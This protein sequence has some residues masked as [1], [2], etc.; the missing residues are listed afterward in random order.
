MS[1]LEATKAV[2]IFGS[3][4]LVLIFACLIWWSL[5]PKPSESTQ[6]ETETLLLNALPTKAI[7]GSLSA[8]G[9][10]ELD[11][12]GRALL[13]F[14]PH[15]PIVA[16]RFSHLRL[17]G[18]YSPMIGFSFAWRNSVNPNNLHRVEIPTDGSS[19]ALGDDP[20]WR[21]GIV[22]ML[23]VVE[24]IYGGVSDA[25]A[26]RVQLGTF[27]LAHRLSRSQQLSDHL[28]SATAFRGWDLRSINSLRFSPTVLA[29]VVWLVLSLA[30]AA[31]VFRRRNPVLAVLLIGGVV[32]WLVLDGLW[33]QQL[34]FQNQ[35]SRHQFA[36][37][38]VEQRRYFDLDRPLAAFLDPLT[39]FAG[40]EPVRRALVVTP[41]SYYGK[42]AA[43]H[44]LP[45]PA[46]WWRN[47]NALAR[48]G[49][50]VGKGDAIVLFQ[51]ESDV[52]LPAILGSAGIEFEELHRDE[53]GV[54]FLVIGRH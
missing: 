8:P 14:R 44:L 7:F 22:E 15:R 5:Q 46:V 26:R 18:Q 20:G 1:K 32:G 33:T 49:A 16:R 27:E 23:L 10:F 31:V 21:G 9:E 28:A 38:S 24:P 29:L 41:N 25:G 35:A 52:N 12:E 43:Y 4:G 3:V 51:T 39:D 42:R 53:S 6:D 50:R 36:G 30:T 37:V 11:E 17:E 19:L 2:A 34:L 47:P 45:L 54:I 13:A 48:P 40:Q